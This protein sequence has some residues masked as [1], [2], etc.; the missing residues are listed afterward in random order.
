MELRER[1]NGDV[2][3]LDLAGKLIQGDGSLLLKDKINS[4]LHQGSRRI[5]LNLGG[6]SYIDSAGL[7]QLMASYASVKRED[8]HLKLFNLGKRAKDVLAMTRLLLVFE[9]FDSEDEAVRSF[10]KD[11]V[12]AETGS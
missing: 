4:V 7:G 5:V 10:E 6:V 11:V 3:V 8:G 1:R 2:V 9:T 12:E